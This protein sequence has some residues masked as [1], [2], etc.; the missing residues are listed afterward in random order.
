MPL[1]GQALVELRPKAHSLK[2][3]LDFGGVVQGLKCCGTL[4]IGHFYRINLNSKLY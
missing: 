2:V 1:I 3:I 4:T